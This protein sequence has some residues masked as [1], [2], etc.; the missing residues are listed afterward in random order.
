MG[1]RWE[2]REERKGR[3]SEEELNK[4]GGEEKRGREKKEEREGERE[5]KEAV[6]CSKKWKEKGLLFQ[7]NLGKLYQKGKLFWV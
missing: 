1:R 6:L 4:R 5:E 3:E 2:G 7:N